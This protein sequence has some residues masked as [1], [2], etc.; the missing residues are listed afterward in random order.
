VQLLPGALAAQTDQSSLIDKI[1]D[2]ENEIADVK[3]WGVEK[4]RYKLITPWQ[5]SLTYALKESTSN[6]EPPHYICTSCYQNGRKSIL[7]QKTDA[8]RWTLY[9]CPVCKS[10][11]PTG[12]HGMVAAEYAQD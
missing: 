12:Y 4:I 8:G 7:N 1:R 11:I 3:A 9:A 10:Q 2:L 6:A 5:G